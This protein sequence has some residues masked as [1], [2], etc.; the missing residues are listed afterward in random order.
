MPIAIR[1]VAH[2]DQLTLVG[3]LDELRSRIIVSLVAVAIAFGFCFW[4]NNALL[5]LIDR[6]L[7]HQT[8]Q[9]VRD[10]HGPLGATY[11]VQE[12]TRDVAVQLRTVVDA[13]EKPSPTA[14]QS[15][16]GPRHR[17]AVGATAGRPPRDPRDRGAVHDDGD[18]IA[19][20]R[21]DPVAADRALAALRVPDAGI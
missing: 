7:A 6:P 4:Q 10:G 5:R 17:P 13:L 1:R 3:H 8:E 15:Q 11:R 19:D 2:D 9:Q 16:P 20:V 18:G 14:R 21:P 12:S